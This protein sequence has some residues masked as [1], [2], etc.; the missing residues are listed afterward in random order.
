[1]PDTQVE[2]VQL[3]GHPASAIAAQAGPVLITDMRQ[4]HHIT[5]LAVRDRAKFR[6]SKATIC[7]PHHTT[8]LRSRK[9]A[10]I[11]VKEC[12]NYLRNSGYGS[13]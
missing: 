10:R 13:V 5:P 2:F 6:L 11:V 4:K 12:E 3:F 8:G 9:R 1:M 7:D